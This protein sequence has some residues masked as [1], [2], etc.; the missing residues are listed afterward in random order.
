M[1]KIAFRDDGL[2]VIPEKKLADFFF[3]HHQDVART[4]NFA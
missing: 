1:P 2:Q 4:E 3:H